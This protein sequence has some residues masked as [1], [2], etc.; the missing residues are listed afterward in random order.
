M[1]LYD[2]QILYESSKQKVTQMHR[3]QRGTC[4]TRRSANWHLLLTSHQPRVRHGAGERIVL[5]LQS[6]S[7]RLGWSGSWVDRGKQEACGHQDDR[8]D[9]GALGAGPPGT[10]LH[11]AH[12]QWLKSH[13]ERPTVIPSASCPEIQQTDVLS[14]RRSEMK[15]VLWSHT[16]HFRRRKVSIKHVIWRLYL[17]CFR[18]WNLSSPT[19][20]GLA[21]TLMFSESVS[22]TPLSNQIRT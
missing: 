15:M 17:G 13:P 7:I 14:R 12:S 4:W 18:K 10:A 9:P 6:V 22:W 5:H 2:T 16:R 11:K 8:W 21:Y 20:S 1:L 3:H 19:A